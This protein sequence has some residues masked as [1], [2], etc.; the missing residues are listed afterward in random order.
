M[1]AAAHKGLVDIHD[2]LPLVLVPEAAREWVK[3]DTGGKEADCL[4]ILSK[5]IF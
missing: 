1:T 5:I 2:R 4:H 3:Q